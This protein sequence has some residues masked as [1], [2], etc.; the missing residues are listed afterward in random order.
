MDHIIFHNDIDGIVSAGVFMNYN[1]CS[2]KFNYF[3]SCLHPVN[4]TMRGDTI[5]R[6]LNKLPENE[7]IAILDFEFNKRADV[8][9]DHHY[10][11]DFGPCCVKTDKVMYNPAAKSAARIVEEYF[12]RTDNH[13]DLLDMV[14]M[15]DSGTYPDCKFIFESDHPLMILRAYLETA[16]PSDVVYSRIVDILAINGCDIEHLIKKMGID[17][18]CV[19]NIK[20]I[21]RKISKDLVKFGACS[22]VH[23]TRQNQFPRYSEFFVVPENEYAIRISLSGPHHKYVQIGSN[24]WREK[25]NKINIGEFLRNLSYCRGGG[26]FSVGAGVIKNEDE[27]KLLDDID[28]YFNKDEGMEKYAVDSEDKVEKRAQELVKTGVDLVEARK[29][30]QKEQEAPVDADNKT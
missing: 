23:Q 6:I 10:S 7:R 24:Q 26:H 2:E 1:K 19:S 8:W 13:S 30:S 12:Q 15:I 5:K 9:I 17:Y 29:K 11:A 28:I 18:Q 25:S 14:D 4:S 20:N 22:C 27:D 3:T 21:A 16:F